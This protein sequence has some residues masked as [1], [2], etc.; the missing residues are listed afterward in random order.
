MARVLDAMAARSGSF[1]WCE[2]EIP[3]RSCE[4][5]PKRLAPTSRSDYVE[6][7]LRF[8]R[9]AERI[10]GGLHLRFLAAFQNVLQGFWQPASKNT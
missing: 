7:R 8:C 10:P 5:S 2:P 6:R 9:I 1:C 3:N 4:S